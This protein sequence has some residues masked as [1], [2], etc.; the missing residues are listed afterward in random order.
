MSGLA[1]PASLASSGFSDGEGGLAQH[2][3]QGKGGLHTQHA[4]KPGQLVVQPEIIVGVL[5]HD[6]Q[7]IQGTFCREE[8]A[9]LWYAPWQIE[10]G[11]GAAAKDGSGRGHRQ[12]STGKGAI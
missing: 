1:S 11:C 5:H 4:G 9:K 3:A 12:P 6:A 10:P 8:P 2:G 7:K